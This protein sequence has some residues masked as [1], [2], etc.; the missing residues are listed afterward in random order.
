MIPNDSSYYGSP[1]YTAIV[2]H[3]GILHFTAMVGC[4]DPKTDEALNTLIQN[5]M[6][7][8]DTAERRFLQ[9]CLDFIAEAREED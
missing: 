4:V 6:N 5:T 7:G 3:H 9:A 2:M 1:L 8:A